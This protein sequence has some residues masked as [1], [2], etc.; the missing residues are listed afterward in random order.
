MRREAHGLFLMQLTSE[1]IP[2]AL[3]VV[4]LMRV[5][6]CEQRIEDIALALK[7]EPRRRRRVRGALLVLALAVL[8]V[9]FTRHS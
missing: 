4:T 6:A 5:R 7:V 1:M 2:L 9:L 3:V 8:L